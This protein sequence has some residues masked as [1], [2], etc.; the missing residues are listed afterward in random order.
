MS[1]AR[2][3]GPRTAFIAI[4]TLLLAACS[5]QFVKRDEFD[6]TVNDL[7]STDAEL[8]RDLQGFRN[9]FSE[10]TQDL[11][12]KFEGYD[13]SLSNLQGRLRVEMSAHFE[14]DRAELREQD[15]PTLLEFS[16][17]VRQYD[18]N[19]VVTVEGFTDPAGDPEYNRQLG[20]RR[21]SAVRDF[22][23][24]EGGL[25]RERVRAVSYGEDNR[26]MLDPGAWGDKG[27]ANR[28]VSLVVD[29]LGPVPGN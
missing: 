20:Q 2:S 9:Q 16:E 27:A 17:V 6:S 11:N 7:R 8:A 23:I 22:L 4:A 18:P 5:S 12:R 10:M 26:R 1:I 28:R 13:A 15:K 14:Y 19:V 29:Y 24:A 3:A 21:A 25:H